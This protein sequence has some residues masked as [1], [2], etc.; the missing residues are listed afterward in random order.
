MTLPCFFCSRDSGR[1]TCSGKE[2]VSVF[3]S[4]GLELSLVVGRRHARDLVARCLP[5]VPVTREFTCQLCSAFPGLPVSCLFPLQ[6][7]HCLPLPLSFVQNG[8]YTQG[9]PTVLDVS[10]L[11]RSVCTRSHFILS[12][13]LSLLVNSIVGPARRNDKVG[14]SAFFLAPTVARTVCDQQ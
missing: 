12:L 3:T 9:H 4:A 2:I 10:C 5:C 1:K 8:T 13:S 7:P 6:A 14:G 11:L